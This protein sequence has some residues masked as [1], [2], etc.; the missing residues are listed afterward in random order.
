MFVFELDVKSHKEFCRIEPKAFGKFCPLSEDIAWAARQNRPSKPVL[1]VGL[2]NL[3]G[4][5]TGM[6][7]LKQSITCTKLLKAH[8]SK[9]QIVAR[10]KH[11]AENNSKPLHPLF[12]LA[13]KKPR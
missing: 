1:R 11:L 9:W 6:H 8:T 7:V 10:L 5:E 4:L 2:C 12:D 13:K 3:T